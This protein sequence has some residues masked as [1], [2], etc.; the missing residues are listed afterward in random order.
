MRRGNLFTN[1]GL[2]GQSVALQ[3]SKYNTKLTFN[4]LKM[5]SFLRKLSKVNEYLEGRK[6]KLKLHIRRGRCS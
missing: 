6:N 1:T 2:N 3:G 4:V 5:F